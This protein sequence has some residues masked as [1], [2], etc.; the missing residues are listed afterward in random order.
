MIVSVM[1]FY[2]FSGGSQSYGCLG[3]T[4]EISKIISFVVF[5]PTGKLFI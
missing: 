2:F 5:F 3:E 4:I 1:L